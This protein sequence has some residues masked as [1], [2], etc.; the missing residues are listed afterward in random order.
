MKAGAQIDCPGCRTVIA[1]LNHEV[2]R[3]VQIGPSA[4]RLV[5][6]WIACLLCC[7][8]TA[9]GQLVRAALDDAVTVGA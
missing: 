4:Y 2:T 9:R 6:P 3:Y 7:K 5:Q 1:T 8:A